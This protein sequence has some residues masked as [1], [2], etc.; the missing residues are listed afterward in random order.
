M[1]QWWLFNS[2]SCVVEVASGT[3][4]PGAYYLYTRV[5]KGCKALSGL[6]LIYPPVPFDERFQFRE[7]L[8]MG[9]KRG[10][11]GAR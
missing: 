8:S 9:F 6:L 2:P 5:E 4:F 1:S 11:Y 7:D 3:L 10:E